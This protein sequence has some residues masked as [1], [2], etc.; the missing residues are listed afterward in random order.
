M[1]TPSRMLRTG[2]ALFV[3]LITLPQVASFST[4]RA[5]QHA[6]H[7]EQTAMLDNQSIEAIIGRSGEMKDNVYKIGLPRTDLKVR[8]A[9]VDLKPALALGSC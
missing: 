7:S 2:F 9:G 5:A 6:N 8:A 3:M 4:L 1:F